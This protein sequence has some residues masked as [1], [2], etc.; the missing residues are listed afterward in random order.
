MR[1]GCNQVAVTPDHFTAQS[2]EFC[3]HTRKALR[4][5]IDSLP[6]LTGKGQG[7]GVKGKFS[8][9]LNGLHGVKTQIA[10]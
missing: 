5:R 7:I 8:L 2:A 10:A 4:V 9:D 6:L 1:S 3:A